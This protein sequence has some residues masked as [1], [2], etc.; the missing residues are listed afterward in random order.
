MGVTV[1]EGRWGSGVMGGNEGDGGTEEKG[2]RE[3]E[4]GREGGGEGDR[5]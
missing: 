2:G 4:G 3:G 5:K 1:Y